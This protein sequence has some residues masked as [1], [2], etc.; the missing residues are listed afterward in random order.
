MVTGTAIE[1]STSFAMM[2]I[3]ITV[4]TAIMMTMITGATEKAVFQ[5][6]TVFYKDD[7]LEEITRKY[8][9]CP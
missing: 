4:A 1:V 6:D 2:M 5:P 8:A 9:Y 3:I 7:T